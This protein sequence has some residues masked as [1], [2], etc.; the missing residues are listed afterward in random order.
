MPKTKVSEQIK[1]IVLGPGSGEYIY[2]LNTV[3]DGSTPVN[4]HNTGK[5]PIF[6]AL[7]NKTDMAKTLAMLKADYPNLK[8]VSIVVGWFG[9][10]TKAGK[11]SIK[12][13]VESR[14]GPDWEVAGMNRKTAY[15]LQK[16]ESG[17]PKWGGTP[18]DKS[19]FE[20][21]KTLHDAGYNV[22][23]YPI[24]YMDD[25]EQTWRGFIKPKSDAE[26]ENFFKEYGK[27]IKHYAGLTHNG[28]KL[29]DYMDD[30]IIG[31]EFEGVTAYRNKKGE[32]KSV[33]ELIKLAGEVKAIAGPDVKLTYAANW[34]E[35][36]HTESGFHPL[37]KLWA[38][39][40][41]D[42]VGIDAYFPLTDGLKQKDITVDKIVEGWHSGVEYDYVKD[43]NKNIPINAEDAIKNLEYWWTHK[44]QDP[45]GK[46]TA[47]EPKMKPVV[48]T[49]VGFISMDGTT[50]EPASY[51]Y[52]GE[53][54]DAQS[55]MPLGSEG[56]VDYKA[57]YIAIQGTEK[58]WNDLH[59][60]NPELNDLVSRRDY[61]KIDARYGY[62]KYDSG[63]SDYY[64]Y[65]HDL[66]VADTL[67]AELDHSS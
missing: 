33:D 20:L 40:N 1:S 21:T 44:H 5:D 18:T 31:T 4:V 65:N 23:L 53:S 8:N 41:I 13:G 12:P 54:T 24:L 59:K 63:D 47:W 52:P 50:N 42:Y 22:T 62:D 39:K 26:V 60:S 34:S 38:D 3:Y 45:D 7:Q 15:E 55:G 19:I 29:S 43:G 48:F 10:T 66:K 46:F 17:S 57:Q 14:N 56:K 9:N 27:V 16:D 35:Y 6:D 49:E 32:F 30:L 25:S 2:S 37:D 64:A 28:E 58:Y 36:H 11:I 67:V 51:Y 61:F